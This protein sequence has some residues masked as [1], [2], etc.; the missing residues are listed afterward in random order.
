MLRLHQKHKKALRRVRAQAR[1]AE[2]RAAVSRVVL[3][4]LPRHGLPRALRVRRRETDLVEGAGTG[5]KDRKRQEDPFNVWVREFISS[6]YGFFSD[7]NDYLLLTYTYNLI[8]KKII[9]VPTP[10]RLYYT[11]NL[12]PPKRRVQSSESSV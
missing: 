2:G 4:P 6:Y 8:Y 12:N 7:E 1:Q 11:Q 5:A 3:H 10:R 9:H